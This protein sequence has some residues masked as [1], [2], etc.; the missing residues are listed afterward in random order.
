[1]EGKEA[2]DPFYLLE[3]IK[4]EKLNEFNKFRLHET[5]IDKTKHRKPILQVVLNK[6][7]KYSVLW[8]PLIMYCQE[9]SRLVVW[10][11]AMTMN[12]VFQAEIP[13]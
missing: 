11:D 3:N 12:V 4:R 5:A 13:S 1:M 8:R 9:I 10:L 7:P 2:N 6:G